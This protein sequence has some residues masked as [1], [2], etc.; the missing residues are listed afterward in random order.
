VQKASAR[1]RVFK[2]A[3]ATSVL[4]AALAVT[5]IPA[6]F[7]IPTEAA[8]LAALP[9]MA[10]TGA[11]R[12]GANALGLRRGSDTRTLPTPRRHYSMVEELPSSGVV[13]DLDVASPHDPTLEPLTFTPRRNPPLSTQ[14]VLASV[15]A[16]PSLPGANSEIALARRPSARPRAPINRGY[17]QVSTALAYA[18][19]RRGIEAPFDAVMGGLRAPDQPDEA[20]NGN[21]P[22][23]RPDPATVLTWLN[24]RALGQFAP[25]QHEWVQNPL[26]A[27]V[28]DDKQQKCLAE[29]VYFEAR[30]EPDA[31]QAAVAQVVLNRVRNPAYPDTICGVVYQNQR[32]R[33]RCQFSFACDGRPERIRSQQAFRTAE[34]IALEVTEGRLWLAEVGDST[35]Y[36]ANYVRPRWGKRMNKVDRIGAHIFYR[37]ILGGWS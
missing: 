25:G 8:I 28:F 13:A 15:F 23:P 36:H 22:R 20:L 21:M 4:S 3:A 11:D 32:S 24:G 33:G 2:L 1:V 34:R 10:L 7:K 9:Q 16:P 6:S 5:A 18:P 19:A 12:V 35:H 17:G 31:G 27:G 30:G 29:A 37:T 26:P 14:E